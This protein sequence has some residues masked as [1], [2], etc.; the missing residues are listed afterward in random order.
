MQG[1]LIEPV[2]RAGVGSYEVLESSVHV[3]DAARMEAVEALLGATF[4][5]FRRGERVDAVRQ[6]LRTLRPVVEALQAAMDL[7]F[8]AVIRQGMAGHRSPPAWC[9][10]TFHETAWPIQSGIQPRAPS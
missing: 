4:S 1:Q 3:S 7:E 10:S 8:E 2:R 5:Y 6:P 9:C